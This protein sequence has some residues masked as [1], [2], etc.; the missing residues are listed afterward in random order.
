MFFSISRAPKE[1]FSKC[2]QIGNFCINT[3][4]GW[5]QAQ[6]KN[7][8]II[9]KGY[10]DDTNLED[11]FDELIK[12]TI[13]TRIGNFCA[14]VVNGD[15]IKISTDLYRGFPIYYDQGQEVTNLIPLSTTVYTDNF[16]TVDPNFV[17]E[18]PLK[19]NFDIIGATDTFLLTFDQVVDKVDEILTTRTKTFLCHNKLPIKTFLSGGVDSLLV[20][21]YLQKYTTNYELVRSSHYDYSRF[22]LMN[23]EQLKKFWGYTQIH[24]WRDQC[25]LTSGAPGDEFM[26]R[27][28]VT[29]NLFLRHRGIKILDLMK[30]SQWNN[31]L[32]YSYFSKP[33]HQ[34]VFNQEVPAWTDVD[35]IKALSDL[36]INDWQHWHLGNTLTWTPLRDLEIFKLFLR[37]DTESAIRQI[38]NSDISRAL[39]ERNSPELVNIISDQKNSGN[40]M[41][42]LV[43]FL[44]LS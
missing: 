25:V 32:H 36:I 42:N 16:I 13:P 20:Y 28:P 22:N 14:L 27:S 11:L 21:S 6:V 34:T 26:L 33:K 18:Y 4:E 24:H 40:Y 30:T 5:N 12:Q 2:Y 44:D 15:Q 38:M 3:D 1:N 7:Y 29:A 17:V 41:K 43:K 19:S 31:C 23:A 37:L 39:I 8:T 35:M 10:A 9:Y